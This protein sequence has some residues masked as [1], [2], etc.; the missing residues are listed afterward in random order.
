MSQAKFDQLRTRIAQDF[1]IEIT[2]PE[3]IV[4]FTIDLHEVLLVNVL[5]HDPSKL[6][7]LFAEALDLQQ[8]SQLDRQP[9]LDQA[10]HFN[11][12]RLAQYGARL[13]LDRSGR[14][15]LLSINARLQDLDLYH[16][17]RML[18]DFIACLELF[19]EAVESIAH[20]DR[21]SA[22]ISVMQKMLHRL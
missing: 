16:F 1:E 9:I 20:S 17:R 3:P 19:L 5:Y 2:G 13:A 12:D 15:L 7:M 8:F 14:Q 11:T 4:G 22:K 18:H 21:R 10:R 6:V